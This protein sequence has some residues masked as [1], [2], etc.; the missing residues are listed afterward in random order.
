MAG[1]RPADGRPPGRPSDGVGA[2]ARAV[3]A[4]R[5]TAGELVRRA[6][7][8]HLTDLDTG[9]ARGLRF[10]PDAAD[11]AL[12]FFGFLR[13]AE[14]AFADQPFVLAPAQVFIVGS[15]FG[16]LGSD[17]FRRFRTAYIEMGKGNGKTPLCAGI[18]LYGLVADE[19]P[20]AQIFAAAVTREQAGVLFADALAM[21]ERSPELRARLSA[22]SHNI[23][24]PRTGSFFRPVS[25][26]GRSL[27]AKRVHMALIDEVHEHR[28]PVVVHKMRA[29]TK[30]RRQAL[31]VEITNSGY[32]RTSV[33]WEHHQYSRDVLEG[34]LVNDAWFGFVAGLDAADEWTDE[35]V[36]P[37]ANPLLDV[38]ISRA[39]LHEQV[40]EALAMTTKRNIVARLNFCVWTE[41][42]TRW[43]DVAAFDAGQ[44]GAGPTPLPSA[45]VAWGGLDLAST[46]D[47]SAFVLLAPRTVCPVPEHAGQC[48]DIRA[49]FWLPE[50][51]M[52]AR[53]RRDHVPYDAWASAGWI[54]L[55]PGNVTDYD[56]IRTGIEALA[57]GLRIRSIGHDRWNATQLVGQ[58]Q[59]DG[60]DLLP[61]GQGYAALTA[62]AK[63]LEVHIAGGLV[64]HDGNPVLRWMVANAVAEIDAAGNIKPSRERSRAKID[65][66]AAWC[67]ALFAWA[68]SDPDDAPE[69]SV[70]ETRGLLRLG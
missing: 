37:K 14:G 65:G 4:G 8:R 47:L 60:F 67:D 36:W 31:I 22:T 38:S 43:L 27:D 54:S 68:A 52:A 16:W 15:L 18:G 40:A 49:Q 13:L 41:G 42:E 29:G 30:G 2:Y 55:T 64:H 11:H 28:S 57:D 25:S 26:E 3:V 17:G 50:A 56:R 9:A 69:P 44:D 7:A 33:C 32:D 70:Y 35:S 1:A 39:Y 24:D 46:R 48:F 66:V 12:R 62:P 20:G 58:L 19:E 6:A 21:V 45:T 63:L 61:V 10:D 34:T 5:I 51:G 23:A 53:V 59:G